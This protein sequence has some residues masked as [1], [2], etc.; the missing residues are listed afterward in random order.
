MKKDRTKDKF[1]GY[2]AELYVM[3]E[4]A[5]RGL[6]SINLDD[7]FGGYDLIIENG[8]RVEVKSSSLIKV[9]DKRRKNLNPREFWGFANIKSKIKHFGSAIEGEFV[10]REIERKEIFCDFFVLVCM[11]KERKEFLKTFIV[12]AEVIGRRLSITIPD[13]FSNRSEFSLEEY[14]DR[15][16]LIIGFDK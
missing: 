4:I 3:L 7:A 6:R 11:D 1:K 9:I 12:P 14:Q 15:W 13:D 16:D 8:A 5:K 2:I 10:K